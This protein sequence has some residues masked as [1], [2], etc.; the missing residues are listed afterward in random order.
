MSLAEELQLPKKSLKE[1]KV[2]T[3]QIL[4]YIP[5]VI[6][7]EKIYNNYVL[8]SSNIAGTRK[9]IRPFN[10]ELFIRN[11][12]DFSESFNQLANITDKLKKRKTNFTKDDFIIIDKTIYT[13]QQAF[14]IGL[15]LLVESNSAK[16]H[17]GNRFEE[18]IKVLLSSINISLKKII[19]NIPYETEEGEK[20]YKCETDIVVS[21]FNK[22]KSSSKNIDEEE[23]IISL[24]TTTKDRM[25]KIFID[26]ILLENFLN[27]PIRVVGISQNDI[28]R[29]G[30]DKISY[31]FVSNLFMVYTKFLIELEGYYYLDKPSRA[32]EKP[33]NQYIDT[34]S[35]F[36]L[37][38]IWELIRT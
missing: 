32:F 28:Q 38:D 23:L 24:K 8:C 30:D 22:V 21:P 20:F 36:L 33:F 11:S 1:F 13:I 18:L 2:V 25:P 29:K 16:K 12:D 17:V 3:T 19:I 37:K 10:K 15:D 14:G 34:F 35:N 26:K 9:Q 4:N 6:N 5:N 31:T 27:H 7:E